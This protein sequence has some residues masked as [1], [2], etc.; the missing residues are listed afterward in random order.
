MHA[1]AIGAQPFGGWSTCAP[2]RG[3][4]APPFGDR[5]ILDNFQKHSC[6]S[7]IVVKL[8]G[9]RFVDEGTDYAAQRPH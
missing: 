3:T 5:H 4:S 2:W 8:N 7:G 1:Q 9:E 6:R